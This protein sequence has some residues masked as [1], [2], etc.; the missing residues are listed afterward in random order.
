MD[1]LDRIDLPFPQSVPEF[2]R[3]SPTMRPVLPTWKRLAGVA[4]SL[5]RTA[6]SRVNLSV[7]PRG[8]AS[9]GNPEVAGEFMPI[10]RLVFNSM[11]NWLNGI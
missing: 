1:I 6:A 9:C 11:K 10:I 8:P 4:V 3:L 5:A 2:Q 7:S